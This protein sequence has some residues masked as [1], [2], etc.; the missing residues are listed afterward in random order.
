MRPPRLP[1]VCL[2][3]ELNNVLDTAVRIDDNAST[4]M[5]KSKNREGLNWMYK[6][7]AWKLVMR[8]ATSLFFED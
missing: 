8:Y 5:R 6:L 4:M 7:V 1:L 2:S 3:R